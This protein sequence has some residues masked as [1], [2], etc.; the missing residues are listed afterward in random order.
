MPYICKVLFTF[1]KTNSHKM[2]KNIAKLTALALAVLIISVTYS[3]KKKKQT[4]QSD[5]DLYE[6]A[7]QTDGYVWYKKT[8]KLLDKS[9]GSGHSQPLLRTRYNSIAATK[10]DSVGKIIAGSTFPEGSIIVKELYDNATTIGRYAI[11]HKESSNSNADEKGWVWGYINADG[12]VAETSTNK[13]NACKS[14]HSQA[15]NIDYALM[16]KFFP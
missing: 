15:G 1:P 4:S 5:I 16:N 7:K 10:L 9:S 12:S 8:D 11:L 3:C 13:G 2:K 6:L 14:C